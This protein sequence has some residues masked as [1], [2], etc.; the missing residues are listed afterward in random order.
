MTLLQQDNDLYFYSLENGETDGR[1]ARLLY[2]L[3]HKRSWMWT[4]YTYKRHLPSLYAA[5]AQMSWHQTF[6]EPTKFYHMPYQKA[7]K[8]DVTLPE[9]LS[10]RP[11]SPQDLEYAHSEYP[12]RHEILLPFFKMI[13]RFN[14]NLAIYDRNDKILAWCLLHLPNTFTGLQVRRNRRRSGLGRVILRNLA[15]TLADAKKDSI[16]IVVDGNMSSAKLFQKEGF[17]CIDEVF[18]IKIRHC[19]RL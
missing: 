12:H 1:L 3:R 18:N 8:L 4:N 10:I 9:G 14:K 11:L 13:H 5:L 7:A 15:K 16:A 6:F 19:S 2:L 17:E